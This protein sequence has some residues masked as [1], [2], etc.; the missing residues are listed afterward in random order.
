MKIPGMEK[1][2]WQSVLSLVSTVLIVVCGGLAFAAGG[3]GG[4]VKWVDTDTYRVMNFAV[5]LG[6]LIFILK[7]PLSNALGSRT[8]QIRTQLADLETKKIEAE[9]V[10][11]EYNEKISMLNAESERIV[12]EYVRQ[13]NEARARIIKEAEMAASK[14]EEQAKRNIENEFMLA[15]QRLQ[16][17][18]LGKAMIKAEEIIRKNITPDDQSRLV[19]EY[20]DKVVA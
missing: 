2:L 9:K 3:G 6:V 4:E 16:Q 12:A 5:L 15:K 1:R 8:E 17:D 11:T 7:K 10:L 18:I 13:G 19:D 14:L 20:L